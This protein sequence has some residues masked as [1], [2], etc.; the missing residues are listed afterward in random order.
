MAFSKLTQS[1]TAATAKTRCDNK[2]LMTLL[3]DTAARLCDAFTDRKKK[4][5]KRNHRKYCH[6]PTHT[7]NRFTMCTDI[8]HVHVAGNM[9]TDSQPPNSS[10]HHQHQ[11]QHE[12][13]MAPHIQSSGAPEIQF[14]YKNITVS[15]LNTHYVQINVTSDNKF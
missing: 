8:D 12:L 6:K 5:R 9:T 13:A 15:Q 3:V 14:N 1:F 2:R 11:H 4:K 7:A 10:L